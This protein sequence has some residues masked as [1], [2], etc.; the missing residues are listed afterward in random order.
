MLSLHSHFETLLGM[1]EVRAM[2]F[3]TCE[4]DGGGQRTVTWDNDNDHV[5]LP[6]NDGTRPSYYRYCLA[7]GYKV[8]STA[9]GNI[10]K[11]WVGFDGYED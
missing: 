1:A 5:Y 4:V 9:T 7:Q 8:R 10:M 6:S 3:V 2:R 11:E